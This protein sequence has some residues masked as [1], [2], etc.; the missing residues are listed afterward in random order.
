M[1]P[2]RW[3]R[4]VLTEQAQAT[5]VAGPCKAVA[6]PEMTSGQLPFP[7]SWVARVSRGA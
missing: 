4:N 7:G 1:I 2:E 5:A 3:V 6:R